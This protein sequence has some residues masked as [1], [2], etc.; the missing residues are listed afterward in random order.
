VPTYLP[1]VAGTYSWTGGVMEDGTMPGL[2]V[3]SNGVDMLPV[4][5]PTPDTIVKLP[6]LSG[7]KSG[8]TAGFNAYRQIAGYV[9]VPVKGRS[10]Y[11]A[12]VWTLP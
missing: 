9:D 11:H 4:L 3:A 12:V 7:G 8:G 2:T 6:L 1:N 10:T 5:W